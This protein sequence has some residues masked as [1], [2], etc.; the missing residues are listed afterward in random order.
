V[1]AALWTIFH[2][3]LASPSTLFAGPDDWKKVDE[4]SNRQR[5]RVD[6]R[7]GARR[8]PPVCGERPFVR[9]FPSMGYWTFS[10][11][12][13]RSS[14][15]HDL[16]AGR[17]WSSR[18]AFREKRGRCQTSPRPLVQTADGGAKERSLVVESEAM[19]LRVGMPV[20]RT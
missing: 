14:L 12:S 9:R 4:N 19:K 11:C 2:S 15:F 7:F 20:G 3:R 8:S 18:E 6:A 1:G 16:I 10:S 13:D 17:E 5:R